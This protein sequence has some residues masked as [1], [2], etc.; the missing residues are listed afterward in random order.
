MVITSFIAHLWPARIAPLTTLTE[1]PMTTAASDPEIVPRQPAALPALRAADQGV[2]SALAA[3][4]AD[5]TKRV[6]RPKL[7][8][9]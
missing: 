2:A 1:T 9:R 8:P 6:W 7:K 4:L 5:N 3:V